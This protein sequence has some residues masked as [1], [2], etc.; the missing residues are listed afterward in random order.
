MLDTNVLLDWLLDRDRDRTSAVD[1]LFAHAKQQ[2]H[3]PDAIIVELAF[4]LEKYYELPRHIVVTNLYKVIHKQTFNCNRTLFQRAIS[5]YADHRS[6]SFLDA[7]LFNYA[8]AQNTL[9][10]WTFDKRL[11]SQSSNRAKLPLN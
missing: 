2:L 6:W 8:E 5:E 10:V 11:V 7:C 4:A 1:K 3:I 9:P